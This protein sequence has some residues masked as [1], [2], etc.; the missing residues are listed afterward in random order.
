MLYYV[1][2]GHKAEAEPTYGRT[3]EMLTYFS[4]RFGVRYPWAKYAQVT[5]F[6]FGGGME[7]TSATTMGERI[8]CDER[9]LLDRTAESI[10]SHELAHQWWGDMVTCRDWSHLWLNEGF[11]SYAEAL[12][13]EHQNGAEEHRPV[14]E[15]LR[16]QFDDHIL[17]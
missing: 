10:V 13:D 11:A 12:W 16:A 4:Q 6:Q 9:S 3:P 7:N 15:L 5:C 14:E 8:L 2:K 1:P 17:P